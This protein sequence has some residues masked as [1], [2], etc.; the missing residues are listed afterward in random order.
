M[1]AAGNPDSLMFRRKISAIVSVLIAGPPFI[2]RL[3][4]SNT[5]SARRPSARNTPSTFPPSPAE[6]RR[7]RGTR[8]SAV[9][10]L[11]TLSSAPLASFQT[12]GF[13]RGGFQIV[14]SVS[15]CA[16]VLPLSSPRQGTLHVL[17]L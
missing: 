14:I 13:C 9:V 1:T 15:A 6:Y 8:R 12:G 17:A 3:W 4:F 10:V 2:N 11:R 7:R 16:I 5:V